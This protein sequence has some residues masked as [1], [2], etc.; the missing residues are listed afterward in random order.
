MSK[1]NV[2]DEVTAFGLQGTVAQVDPEYVR[3]NFLEAG[4]TQTFLRDGRQDVKHKAAALRLVYKPKR[5]IKKTLYV[6]VANEQFRYIGKQ[7][8]EVS[9]AYARREDAENQ[10][11]KAHQVVSLEIE[12]EE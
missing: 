5:T 2:G 12:I 8:H 9:Y 4:F 11:Y 3:V 6:A 1:F 7:A 10:F